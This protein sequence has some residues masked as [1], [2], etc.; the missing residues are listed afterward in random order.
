MSVFVMAQRAHG[1]A[2]VDEFFDVIETGANAGPGNPAFELRERL[3]NM[4][5]SSKTMVASTEAIVA[6]TIKAMNAY[7]KGEKVKLLRYGK[8]EGFP[9]LIGAEM[10]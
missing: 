1:E 10:A 3:I 8:E 4:R 2:I 5:G 9:K 7:I 6:M